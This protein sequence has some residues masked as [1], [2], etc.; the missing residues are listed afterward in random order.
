MQKDVS[1]NTMSMS[2]YTY[3]KKHYTGVNKDLSGGV[4]ILFLFLVSYEIFIRG[5]FYLNVQPEYVIA[6]VW[7]SFMS[8]GGAIIIV[9]L[10]GLLWATFCYS[11]YRLTCFDFMSKQYTLPLFSL[12]IIIRWILY[13][14]DV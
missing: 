3:L 11:I 12:Y 4:T 13:V 14:F 1:V 5:L 2:Y 9:A 7:I 8:F 10:G 6:I